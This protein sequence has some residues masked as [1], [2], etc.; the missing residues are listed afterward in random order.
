M[1]RLKIM[2][3]GP[4]Q[5]FLDEEPVTGFESSKVRALL[6]YLAAEPERPVRRETLA[7]LLWPDWPDKS[8]LRNL[9]FALADLRKNIADLSA[10]LAG[11]LTAQPGERGVGGLVGVRSQDQRSGDR[12]QGAG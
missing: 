5:V 2:L 1:P 12:G 7:T 9:T 6:I 4:F 10:Y 11:E 8:A 3:M